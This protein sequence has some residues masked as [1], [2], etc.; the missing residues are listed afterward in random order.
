[1]KHI[2]L[3]LSL[4]FIINSAFTQCPEIDRLRPGGYSGSGPYDSETII[5][6][7]NNVVNSNKKHPIKNYVDEINNASIDYIIERGGKNFY[8]NTELE[9]FKVIYHD[10]SKIRNFSEKQHNLES[11]G[12]ITYYLSYKYKPDDTI[13]Y[14]FAIKF[15]KSGKI[16]SESAFPN[17]KMNENFEKLITPCKAV[18]I[19]KNQRM[20]NIEPILSIRLEYEHKINAFCWVVTEDYRPQLTKKTGAFAKE[21]MT[22][23]YAIN[24]VYIN[25][26]TEII[27]KTDKEFGVIVK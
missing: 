5:I 18:E 3:I 2:F 4:I 19:A 15:D 9:N 23:T 20:V 14:N 27:V 25:A 7:Y 24:S 12:K 16:I 21:A 1:M 26:N 11:C 8:D 10:F 6:S 13:V 17:I 22:G